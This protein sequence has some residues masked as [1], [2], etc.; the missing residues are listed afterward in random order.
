MRIPTRCWRRRST[1]E[2]DFQYRFARSIDQGSQDYQVDPYPWNYSYSTGPSDFDAT[3]SYKLWGMWT[4][5][6]FRNG[7]NYAEKILGGW[8]ISGILTGH[9][10]FPWS[11][12]YCGVDSSVNSAYQ[13]Q[14]FA[15]CV[16]P[17]TYAGGAGTNYSNA[18]FL[19]A[20]NF[21]RGA[22]T[23]FTAPTLSSNALLFGPPAS[24]IH[25]NMFR[26][27]GF[28]G[29]DF[30]LAKA[31]GLPKMKFLGESAKLNLQANFYNMFNKLNLTNINN[32]IGT[33]AA[34]GT[35]ASGNATF[36]LAQ[37]AFAGRTVELQARFSF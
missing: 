16:L 31:F 25:R 9:S 11:P 28:F 13:T 36:G 15:N 37:G 14:G 5:N 19:G 7:Q 22:L 10:G 12:Q 27:P 17:E 33:Y 24:N 35:I 21:D 2:L 4:P 29:D 1:V 18:T 20:G 30:T 34:N 8:T 26:G 23:Y 32:T 3:Q 6:I